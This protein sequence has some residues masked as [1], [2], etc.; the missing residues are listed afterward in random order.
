MR[1]GFTHL[2]G[3]H[4]AFDLHNPVTDDAAQLR[5][6]Q[7]IGD[8]LGVILGNGYFPVMDATSLRS[9]STGTRIPSVGG[10][11]IILSFVCD[12]SSPIEPPIDSIGGSIGDIPKHLSLA[13]YSVRSPKLNVAY[14]IMV[15]HNVFPINEPAQQAAE[16]CAALM[17]VM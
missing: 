1:I 10:T 17:D 9:S 5:V 4:I 16:G 2:E 12:A 11:F 3:A 8:Q 7:E 6:D 14:Q 13:S 15:S